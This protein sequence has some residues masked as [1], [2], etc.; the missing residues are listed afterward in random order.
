[1]KPKV[2]GVLVV[3]ILVLI[4]MFQN[5]HHVNLQ[6]LFW[7]ITSPLILLILVSVIVGFVIGYLVNTMFAISRRHKANL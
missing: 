6:I 3:V 5:T 7:Q 2:V 4:I 1:M